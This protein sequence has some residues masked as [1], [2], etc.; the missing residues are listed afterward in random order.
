MFLCIVSPKSGSCVKS[1]P[2]TIAASNSS[3]EP[4]KYA[5][6]SRPACLPTIGI[7][8]PAINLASEQLRLLSI[9]ACRRS[10]DFSPKPSVLTISSRYCSRS[11]KSPK[12]RIHPWPMNFSSV[13]AE[14]PSMPIRV[15]SQKWS[16]F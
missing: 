9:D 11:Y 1:K 12:L 13:V 16:N 6:R 15:F 4:W 10:N 3:Q 7:P 14:R 5:S 8:N 2:L